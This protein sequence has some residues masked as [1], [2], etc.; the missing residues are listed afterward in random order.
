MARGSDDGRTRKLEKRK[1][2]LAYRLE[3]EPVIMKGTRRGNLD[4]MPSLSTAAK[5]IKPRALKRGLASAAI[6]V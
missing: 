6:A 2:T 1:V 4:S 5:R 3:H